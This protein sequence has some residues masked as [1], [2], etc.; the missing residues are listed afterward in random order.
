MS[1]VR[2]NSYTTFRVAKSYIP[3]V[4]SSAFLPSHLVREP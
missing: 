4:C 3:R 2:K 1:E